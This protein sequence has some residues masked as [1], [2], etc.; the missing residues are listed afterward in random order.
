MFTILLSL[1]SIHIYNESKIVNIFFPIN[2]NICFEYPQ[3]MFWLR[4]NK[5]YFLG[6]HSKPVR[7][8]I[9]HHSREGRCSSLQNGPQTIFCLEVSYCK[10][11]FHFFST[12]FL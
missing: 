4:N 7:L 5:N 3:H 10:S 8:F 11:Y 12:V 2:F 1:Y 6:S 9:Q